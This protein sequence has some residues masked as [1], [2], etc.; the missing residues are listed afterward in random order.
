MQSLGL[1]GR[2]TTE[3]GDNQCY[4]IEHW[5]PESRDAEGNQIPTIHQWYNVPGNSKQYRVSF[6]LHVM[7][8]LLLTTEQAT[9]AHYEFALNTKGG[10]IYGLFLESPQASAKTIW[11]GGKTEPNKDDLPQ[12][13]A[14]S[15]ILWGFWVRNNPNVKNIRYFFMIGISNDLTNQIIASCLHGANKELSEWPGTDFSTATD[16]GHALLGKFPPEP[17]RYPKANS[18]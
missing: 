1:D 16:Q 5:D 6:L 8:K 2:P 7:A 10:A 14:F 3:G 11:G 18:Y 17:T 12:L 13:R 4:R 9:K 15:D